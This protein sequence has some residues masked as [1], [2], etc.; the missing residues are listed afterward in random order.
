M[1][2]NLNYILH[3]NYLKYMLFVKDASPQTDLTKGS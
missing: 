2:L 3:Y 1:P